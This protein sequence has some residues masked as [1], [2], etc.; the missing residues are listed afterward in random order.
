[1]DYLMTINVGTT[2]SSNIHCTVNPLSYVEGN[3]NSLV[4]LSL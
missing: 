3:L 2:L 4:S 1:M